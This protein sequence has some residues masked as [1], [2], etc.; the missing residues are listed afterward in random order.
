M[1]TFDPQPLRTVPL[2]Q[3]LGVEVRGID[4]RRPLEPTQHDALVSLLDEHLLLLFRAQDLTAD[5][6][7]RFVS[8]FGPLGD[9]RENGAFHSYISNVRK[10][11]LLTDERLPFP[12]DFTY[13]KF[14]HLYLS[15]YG[16]HVEPPPEPTWFANRILAARTMPDDLRRACEGLRVIHARDLT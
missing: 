16:E 1:T 2:S 9:E 14:P 15:L 8:A 7:I 3:A 6:Q 5:D 12:S 10:D 4:L 13:T 11:T